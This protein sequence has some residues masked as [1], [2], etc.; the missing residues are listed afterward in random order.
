MTK[1]AIETFCPSG[2]KDWRQWLEDNHQTQEAVWLIQYKKASKKASL[3]WEEAVEE[4]LCFGWIDGKRKSISN[5]SYQ[6]FFC[7]RKASSTWSQINKEKV[8]QLMDQGHMRKAGMEAIETAKQNGSWTILDG[9]EALVIPEDLQVAF[10]G[11]LGSE[12]TFSEWS[13]S[14]KKMALHWIVMAKR[15]ETRKRR[16]DKVVSMAYKKERPKIFR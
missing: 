13:K 5:E 14:T 7:K 4:A 12:E 2:R 6:Q 8:K 11:Y 15:P 3:S 9:V 16:I 1:T 10:S